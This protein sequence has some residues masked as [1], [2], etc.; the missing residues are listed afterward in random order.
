MVD[1]RRQSPQMWGLGQQ[2]GQSNVRQK[3]MLLYFVPLAFPSFH[4]VPVKRMT[5]MRARIGDAP[6]SDT[7]RTSRTRARVRRG[8]S[9]KHTA[10]SICLYESL[11]PAKMVR[12]VDVYWCLQSMQLN[13]MRV[14]THHQWGDPHSSHTG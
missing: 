7:P 9:A 6:D 13:R 4:T 8:S 12:D 3:P 1:T 5:R 10:L 2:R 11:L 14:L